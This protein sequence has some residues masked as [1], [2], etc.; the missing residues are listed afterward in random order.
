MKTHTPPNPLLRGLR[1]I[2]LKG[3]VREVRIGVHD[4]EKVKPQ[5]V[6]FDIDLYVSLD[7]FSPSNDHIQ[8]VVDYD[9]VRS[10]VT[11]VTAEP[12]IDL[13]ETLCDRLL[14][15][16]IAH[17]QVL[18]CQVSTRKP[19]VY[20]DCDAVGVEA[21]RSKKGVQESVQLGGAW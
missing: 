21:F 2:F 20:P 13:Q 5:R 18:A 9:F 3:L 1:R 10:V 12:H 7:A 8:E 14:D 6:I 16:L 15:A 4:F 11:S 17:P 19:D